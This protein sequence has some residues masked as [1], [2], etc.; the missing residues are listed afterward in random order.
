M[1]P[2]DKAD[3][4]LELARRRDLLNEAITNAEQSYTHALASIDT[5]GDIDENHSAAATVLRTSTLPNLTRAI[6]YLTQ[7]RGNVNRSIANVGR[8]KD[9]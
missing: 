5:L 1:E 6:W 9:R 3:K 8:S 2:K 4:L 7:M